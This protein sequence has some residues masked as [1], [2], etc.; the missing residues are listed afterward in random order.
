MI[1]LVYL[2]CVVGA[3]WLFVTLNMWCEERQS[4]ASPTEQRWVARMAL[5]APVWPVVLLWALGRAVWDFM[6]DVTR[7][8]NG[9]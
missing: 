5:L 2:Y 1:L 7:R 4:G 8:G 9:L 6:V 3:L